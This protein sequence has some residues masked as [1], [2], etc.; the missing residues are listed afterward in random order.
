MAEMGG[1]VCNE[2]GDRDAKRAELSPFLQADY[3][4]SQD[5]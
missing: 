5:H 2:K 3:R 1:A 4:V